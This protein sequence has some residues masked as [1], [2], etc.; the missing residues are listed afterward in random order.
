MTTKLPIEYISQYQKLTQL[1]RYVV[2]SQLCKLWWWKNLHI[3]L[4]GRL[5]CPEG[6][7]PDENDLYLQNITEEQLE[8]GLRKE[9]ERDMRSP[10]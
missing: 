10:K 6:W 5:H 2:W 7:E 1:L 8:D 9:R 4:N 3:D